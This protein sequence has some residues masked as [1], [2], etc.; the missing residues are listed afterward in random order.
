MKYE[1]K[2]TVETIEEIEI[3]L[4]CYF[5]DIGYAPNLYAILSEKH[6]LTVSD[7]YVANFGAIHL[8]QA[9]KGKHITESEFLVAYDKALKKIAYP[10]NVL[11]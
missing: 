5:K 11:A 1:I 7:N 9:L 4:P 8:D 2:K 10:L 6:I 3:E